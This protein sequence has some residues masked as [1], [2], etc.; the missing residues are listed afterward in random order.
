MIDT[1]EG[2]R[3]WARSRGAFAEGTTGSITF[4]RVAVLGGSVALLAPHWIPILWACGFDLGDADT[5]SVVGTR[6][7]LL[8]TG[9]AWTWHDDT[10]RVVWDIMLVK[11]ASSEL[12]RRQCGSDGVG[13]FDRGCVLLAMLGCNRF[14]G[15]GYAW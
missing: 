3:T 10:V 15:G 6:L 1:A 14:G 9:R 5:T 4:V 13:F 12:P 2:V 7:R 11:P 8:T